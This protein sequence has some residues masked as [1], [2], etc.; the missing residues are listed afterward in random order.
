VSGIGFVTDSTSLIPADLRAKYDI[1]VVS[2][3]FIFKNKV[4]RDYVDIETTD[5]WKMY[6]GFTEPP[7]TS[8]G[9]SGDFYRAFMD[10]AKT[11]RTIFCITLSRVLSATWG[12]ADQA[13][14]MAMETDVG[15]DIRMVDSKTCLGA[16]GLLVLEAARAA[17]A[18]KNPAEVLT[19]VEDLKTRVKYFMVLE[20]LRSL[21][22]VGRAPDGKALDV[23]NIKPIMGMVSNKGVVE[24]LDKAATLDEGIARAVAM[25][26][27]YTDPGKPAHFILHYPEFPEKCEQI[28]MDLLSRYNCAEVLISQ[29]T[30]A[31]MVATGPMYA[32]GFYA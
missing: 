12:S 10:L 31:T 6:P 4:Y 7:T 28:K 30:P 9:A 1:R 18:G 22:K 32:F 2:M 11:R 17:A 25:V 24:N 5:F 13:A 20:S 26:K 21:M 14:K 19:L 8:A 23:P 27:N 3:G 16:L 29:F 15:L